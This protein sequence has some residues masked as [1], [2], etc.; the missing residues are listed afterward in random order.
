[1]GFIFPHSH[2][3]DC[4][5]GANSSTK[6]CQKLPNGR[7]V[8][9]LAT[10][11]PGTTKPSPSS[12]PCSIYPVTSASSCQISSSSQETSLKKATTANP[13]TCKHHANRNLNRERNTSLKKRLPWNHV[14]GRLSCFAFSM[15]VF[16]SKT[17]IL[18]PRQHITLG[19]TVL[20]LF[21]LTQTF[22]D[23]NYNTEIRHVISNRTGNISSL[24]FPSAEE[25]YTEIWSIRA[26]QNGTVTINLIYLNISS[27]EDGQ[28]Q[29]SYLEFAPVPHRKF[30]TP[31]SSHTY[32]SQRDHVIVRFVSNGTE[33]RG[34][35]FALEYI[36]GHVPSISPCGKNEFPCRNGKCILDHW[37]CNKRD[38]CGDNS[39]EDNCSN[40]ITSRPWIVDCNPNWQCHSMITRNL[41]CLQE[42]QICDGVHNCFDMRDEKDCYPASKS[43][44]KKDFRRDDGS[45]STPQIPT[46]Y[47]K[48]LNCQWSV[49]VSG[50]NARVQ[51]TFRMLLFRNDSVTIYNG[52]DANGRVLKRF[53]RN[54]AI[55]NKLLIIE[56]TSN[57]M[58]IVYHTDSLKPGCGINANFRRRGCYPGQ[59][60]CGFG[61]DT[62]YYSHEHCDGIWHC[63]KHGGDERGCGACS[64]N[65]FSCGTATGPCYTE[66]ERCDG[67]SRCSNSADEL[68]CTP[69][70]C[71]FNGTFLCKNSRC[72]YENWKCD[73]TDDCGDNSDEMNCPSSSNRVILVAVVGSLTCA[74]L[75]VI[76]LGFT[77]KLNSLRHRDR[78]R[79]R[80]TEPGGPLTHWQSEFMRRPAPP[81]YCEAMI[82]SMPFEEAQRIFQERRRHSRRSN[83]NRHRSS[84]GGSRTSRNCSA[85]GSQTVA[86]LVEQVPAT[87]IT[88]QASM[89]DGR[90]GT[91]D[92]PLLTDG[93]DIA[94]NSTNTDFER[95]GSTA[96]LILPSDTD[97]E[98]G[99]VGAQDS[100][101]NGNGRGEG[102]NEGSNGSGRGVGNPLEGETVRGEGE[103][104]HIQFSSNDIT[105]CWSR[106]S[107]VKGCSGIPNE[108]L[109][110]FTTDTSSPETASA[111]CDNDITSSTEL[112]ERMGSSILLGTDDDDKGST[113]LS[114]GGTLSGDCRHMSSA[115]DNNAIHLPNLHFRIGSC[116]SLNSSQSEQIPHD[117]VTISD[118]LTAI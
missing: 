66:Q 29:N 116:D 12:S 37:T 98:A 117:C 71:G 55:S 41:M 53:T 92:V 36:T 61:E 50:P 97:S 78:H 42:Y 99:D 7:D 90:Q 15:S 72:V 73:Y 77:C 112:M 65:T 56:S 106:P 16:L 82:T 114:Q 30:C 84:N 68:H 63:K 86:E 49:H 111:I 60:M 1:M 58:H 23:A 33:A 67:V 115:N 103:Q 80:L 25:S 69:D 76:A 5:F 8:G 93:Q 38:E 91:P 95:H 32:I 96:A 6:N 9:L 100:V 51:L 46:L 94:M 87:S 79:L 11:K 62:C 89:D 24:T 20:L 74:L 48:S 13:I 3:M 85:E 70:K 28:C 110:R 108:P 18:L 26:P 52:N 44:C 35:G 39:D 105:A 10:K 21:G 101:H 31:S 43:I 2:S 4:Q 34:R 45:F 47:N 54:N 40:L 88:E 17:N 113:I 27:D 81:S 75:L 83:R 59:I 19:F 118:S 107:P 22:V 104:D 14:D 109:L 64:S 102:P 57:D